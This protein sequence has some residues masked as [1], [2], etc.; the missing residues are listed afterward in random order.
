MKVYIVDASDME[1]HEIKGIFLKK[2]MAEVRTKSVA[3]HE[4][5]ENYEAYQLRNPW[6]KPYK[7]I[8][9]DERWIITQDEFPISTFGVTEWLVEE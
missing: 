6:D 3:E 4:F 7:L 1:S 5:K 2:E 9:R 8:R